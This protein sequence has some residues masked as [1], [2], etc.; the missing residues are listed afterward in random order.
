MTY[1]TLYP[2]Q[3]AMLVAL[4]NG[5]DDMSLADMA[6]RA[7]INYS[8]VHKTLPLLL[9]KGLVTTSTVGRER[10]IRLTKRGRLHARMHRNLRV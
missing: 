6:K 5:V 8:Y 2:K 1:T 3:A 10:R 9:D 4:D 7:D